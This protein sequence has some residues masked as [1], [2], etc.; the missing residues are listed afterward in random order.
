MTLAHEF[1]LDGIIGPTHNYAGLSHGN[2][3]STSHRGAVSGPRQAALQ[4]LAK[5]KLLAELGVHQA[6]LPPQERPD[7]GMLRRLGYVG[8]DAQIVERAA[9]DAPL[10]LASCYSASSMWAANAATVSPSADTTDH[11]AHITPANLISQLHRSIE[12]EATHR[13]MQRLFANE[14]HFAVHAPLPAAAHLSDEGAANH[15][16]LC[17]NHGDAGI[18]IFT[19]GRD[20]M[21]PATSLPA[22]F[23]ARQTR[24][25]SQTI[26][27]LHGLDGLD[28]FLVRQHPGA[29]DAGVFHNDVI[30]VGNQDFFLCHAS[31]YVN[32]ERFLRQVGER[33]AERSGKPLKTVV[34][35]EEE[36]P[37]RDAVASYL[38][39]SQIVTLPDGSMSIICPIECMEHESTRNFLDELLTRD[40]PIRSRHVVDLRQSMNNG[41]GPACLR[42]RIVL[43]DVEL[44]A[45]HQGVIWTPS[46][47]EKLVTWVNQH[48]REELRPEDLRDVKL[49]REG[50]DALDE[51][52]RLLDLRGLHDF[53]R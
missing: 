33:F 36:V 28:T 50:R 16:R 45:M 40:T 15:T 39:N 21:D 52:S 48:Y 34:V 30:A 12:S 11:R 7:L 22:K 46:L 9:N 37:L 49:I 14:E 6:V 5:M 2:L 8:S 10:L 51:L 23:P 35:R 27:Q 44:R 43:T 4:G 25:A 3:A 32:G 20:A 24:E 26:A 53:Q 1:N 18:E 29:I 17:G 42:L 13:L 19:F 31:A 47:H 38:F 41:G